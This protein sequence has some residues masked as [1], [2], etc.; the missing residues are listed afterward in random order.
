M[1]VNRE[2]R[3]LSLTTAG[4][5]GSI[6]TVRACADWLVLAFLLEKDTEEN[7]DAFYRHLQ[8]QW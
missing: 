7:L 5:D 1:H 4:C 2:K 6:S 8:R 3:L